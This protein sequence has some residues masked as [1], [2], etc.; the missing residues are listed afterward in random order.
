MARSR[1]TAAGWIPAKAPGCPASRTRLASSLNQGRGSLF[2]TPGRARVYR[3]LIVVQLALTL[4]LAN[5]AALMIT[6]YLKLQRSN[7]GFDPRGVTVVSLH[8]TGPSYQSAEQV[9]AYFRELLPRVRSIPGVRLVATTSKLPLD[10]G[11]NG[12]VAFEG[13][14][15]D[16]GKER[17][18]LVERSF[19]NPGYF[20][21]L[22]I[23]LLQGRL[24]AESDLGSDSA[25]AIVNQTMARMGWPDS[26]PIGKRFALDDDQQWITVIGVVADVRQWGAERPPLPEYYLPLGPHPAYWAGWGFWAERTFLMVKTDVPMQSILEPLKREIRA[27]SPEQA[28]SE[29]R[30]MDEVVA[31]MTVRRRFNTLLISTFAAL[32]LVL[33]AMGVFG[34]MSTFVTQRQHEIGVRMALGADV[35]RV[36]GLILGYSTRLLA[37]GVVVG[38]IGLL[39]STRLI[40]SLLYAVSPTDPTILVGGTALV[41]VVGLIGAFLPA[42]RATR[43]EPVA[44]LRS[45]H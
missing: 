38:L 10:G 8:L 31:S 43:V 7:H 24:P 42:L 1:F 34:M 37:T 15:G 28:V 23:P 30:T 18:P 32:S 4:V 6:S 12:R 9:L 33:V 20:R 2:T 45:E 5:G 16:W 29:V 13:R 17:G 19:V 36:M 26:D 41:V 44:A 40:G 11:T 35:R 25:V 27:V 22:G 3:T 39:V 14:E 21:A